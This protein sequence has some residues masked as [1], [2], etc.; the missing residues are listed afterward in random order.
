IG[1]S[2]IVAL[3]ASLTLTPALLQL[4]GRAAF[5]PVGVPEPE[6]K[7]RPRK[8]IWGRLAAIV[9]RH[10][11]AV[12]VGATLL[13]VPLAILGL[14]VRPSYRATAEL[15]SRATSVR[16]LEALKL[17]FTAGEVGPITILLESA[18]DWDSSEG[19]SLV[20]V[21]SATLADMDNVAEVRS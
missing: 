2:L 12:G 20:R 1:V 6:R 16:G 3:A 10:P 18:N 19:R 15:S 8:T 14:Q 21:L 17:H 11:M 5:W 7:D 9:V 4:L 13:L